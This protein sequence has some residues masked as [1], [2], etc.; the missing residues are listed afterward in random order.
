MG[1]CRSILMNGKLGVDME[2]ISDNIKHVTDVA[3]IT[4]VVGTLTAWL[5][6]IAALLSIVWTLLR[7][8][9][10]FTGK[11]ISERRRVERKPHR[12]GN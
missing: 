3:A 12:R 11:T 9:E 10:M 7:I 6:P 5:P 4:T 1:Y 8:W 2:R